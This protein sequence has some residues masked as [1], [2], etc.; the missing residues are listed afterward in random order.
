MKVACYV[1]HYPEISETFVLEHLRALVDRGHDVRVLAS[2]PGRSSTRHALAD[3]LEPAVRPVF[4]GGRGLTDLPRHL[5]LALRD[6]RARRCLS[7][8]RFGK[9]ATSRKVL[10]SAE[11]WLAIA[12]PD[13]VL[14]EHG[15]DPKMFTRL[16]EAGVIEAPMVTVFH[17]SYLG[18]PRAAERY[19]AFFG[20]GAAFVANSAFSRGR[21]L[22]A[23]CPDDKLRVI[24]MGVRAGDFDPAPMPE[25]R[26]VLLSIARLVEIKGLEYALRGFAQ[27]CGRGID[28]EFRLIGDGPLR[29]SLGSL[30][31]ELGIEDRVEF[32]G[33]RA[34]DE[35]HAQLAACHA[36]ICPSVTLENGNAEAL[37]IAPM[38]AMAMQRPVIASR[39][40]GLPEVVGEGRTG[41]LVPERDAG[42][43]ADAIERLAGDPDLRVSLGAAGRERVIERFDAD[44]LNAELCTLLEK[45]A[46]R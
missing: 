37:G 17:G 30:A 10:A 4:A 18:G 11:P 46:R 21:L 3:R 40:G 29:D 14:S 23:G 43:I 26:F 42:A 9:H 22:E 20:F 32:L 27:A 13:V 24:H 33:A 25:G 6:A 28:A 39:S 36:L 19:R 38:E 31:H 41:L 2:G 12:P 35:V 8:R 16:H 44:R 5:G 1:N 7:V 34:R 15:H 45:A